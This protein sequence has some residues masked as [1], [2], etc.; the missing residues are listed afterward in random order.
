MS[1]PVKLVA[2]AVAAVQILQAVKL[3]MTQYFT[4]RPRLPS[5][6]PVQSVSDW[7]MAEGLTREDDQSITTQRLKDQ[8]GD[9]DR[10]G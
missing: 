10:G 6:S 9:I 3:N 4:A 2:A 8:L 5:A 7:T 1:S